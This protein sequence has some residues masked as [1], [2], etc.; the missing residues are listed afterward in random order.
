MTKLLNKDHVAHE[1]LRT[2]MYVIVYYEPI[3]HSSAE[4]NTRVLRVFVL[5]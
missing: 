5:H 3:V 2:V 1:T 4:K